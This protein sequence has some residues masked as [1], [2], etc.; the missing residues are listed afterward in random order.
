MTT[1]VS[2]S[3]NRANST[4]SLGTADTGQTWIGITGTFGISSN[5]AVAYATIAESQINTT[6][7]DMDSSVSVTF[8]SSSGNGGVFVRGSG[9][10]SDL[11]GYYLRLTGGS[12]SLYSIGTGGGSA[13][14]QSQS[15]GALTYP[16]TVTLRMTIQGSTINCYANGTQLFGGSI[17]NTA[18]S[19]SSYI[20]AG[21]RASDTATTFDNFSVSSVGSTAPTEIDASATGS[22]TGASSASGVSIVY[23][24][25]TGESTG[26]SNAT[27]TLILY[28]TA[29]GE[30]TG[31]G[32]ASTSGELDASAT[33]SATGNGTA[34]SVAYVYA[35]AIGQ[36]TGGATANA[37]VEVYGSAVGES[38]GATSATPLLTLYASATG[39]SVGESVATALMVLFA[40]AVGEATGAGFV[41]NFKTILAQIQLL[42][43]LDNKVSLT[44]SLD[45]KISLQAGVSP[46]A[47]VS[48]NF[49]LEQYS[50][51]QLTFTYPGDL[52]GCT[53]EWVMQYNEASPSTLVKKTS[54]D[55]ISITSTSSTQST[56][57]VTISNAD[58]SPSNGTPIQPGS[59]YHQ[60]TLTDA[61]GE[62]N[63]V[64]K[65]RVTVRA[66]SNT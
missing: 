1:L 31:N 28:A 34:S 3:F 27:S 48:Q 18:V 23:A 59:Y 21:L 46:T 4:T 47:A 61:L 42:A 65:G 43:S 2:D 8:A 60:A 37:V 39:E 66:S 6:V 29:T 24:S 49:T 52:T 10:S 63:P 14:I 17:T 32:T 44:S 33:G 55:G 58:M 35:T 36:A 57:V 40:E 11:S 56:F 9:S 62:S 30:A 41:N 64:S 5:Q 54:A 38:T 20:Y 13:S 12:Y 45:N 22:S 15:A 50:S 19:G 53:L 51:D 26:A 7:T 25:A 16:F